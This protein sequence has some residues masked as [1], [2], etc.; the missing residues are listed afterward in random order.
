MMAA[1]P[2]ERDL[3]EI[4][5]RVEGIE[6][7]VDLLVRANRQQIEEDLVKF[8]GRSRDRVKIFLKVNGEKTVGQIADELKMQGPNVS[9]RITELKKEGL[10]KVKKITREGYVYEQTEKVR[11]LNLGRILKSKFGTDS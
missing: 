9:K 1:A 3:R 11:I 2:S 6:K 4:K 5:W 7:S 10:I 8:F